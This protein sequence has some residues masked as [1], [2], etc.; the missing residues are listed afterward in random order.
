MVDGR[1]KLIVHQPTSERFDDWELL[2]AFYEVPGHR[3]VLALYVY[4]IYLIQ[5][6]T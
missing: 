6:P 2:T 3:K 5:Y 4:E 1:A